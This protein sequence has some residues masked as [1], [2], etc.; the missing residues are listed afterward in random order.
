MFDWLDSSHAVPLPPEYPEKGRVAARFGVVAEAG[1]QPVPDV[2]VFHQKE[3]G[4]RSEDL[5]VLLQITAHWIVPERMPFPQPLTIAKRMGVSLRTVQRTLTRLR[6][7]GLIGKTKNEDGRKA[8]DLKPLVE[9]LEP[10]ARKRIAQ[11]AIV[12]GQGMA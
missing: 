8:Y 5:N 1:F 12:H 4:L 3:L 2:L 6:K 10:F 7:L 9:R 11:R